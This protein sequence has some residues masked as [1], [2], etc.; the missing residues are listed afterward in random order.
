[1]SREDMPEMSPVRI[2]DQDPLAT[3]TFAKR[4]PELAA[5]GYNNFL[6]YDGV[7]HA[8]FRYTGKS[9]VCRTMAKDCSHCAAMEELAQEMHRVTKAR[10]KS[11]ARRQSSEGGLIRAMYGAAPKT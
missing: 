4:H 9:C 7:C 3:A 2:A 1:M 11:E 5:A 10:P 6:M 8:C